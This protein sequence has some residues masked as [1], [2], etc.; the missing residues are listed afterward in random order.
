M[1]NIGDENDTTGQLRRE[2]AATYTR[3]RLLVAGAAAAV[4][5]AIWAK[6]SAGS[7]P[8]S[9]SSLPS[10]T[11]P[12]LSGPITVPNSTIEVDST[13][14]ENGF[15][16]ITENLKLGMVSDDVAQLQERLV[17]LKFDPGPV[18]GY[19]GE[20]TLRSAWAFQKL[21][22]QTPRAEAT[23]IITPTDWDVL[24]APVTIKPRRSTNGQ[25]N[26]TE[27]YLPE[28]VLAIFHKDQAVLVSHMASGKLDENGDPAEW[29][30]LVT[31]DT[32]ET[33]TPLEEPVERDICGRSKTP[34]GVFEFTRRVEGIR[35]GALGSMWNPVYFNFGIAIHGAIN[36]PAEPTSHGCVRLPMHIG[37]YFQDLVTDGDR[38]LVWNGEQPPEQVTEKEM[39]PVFDYAN[40]DATTTTTSTTST[41]T[42]TVPQTTTTAPPATTTPT[43][44]APTT[45]TTTVPATTSTTSVPASTTPLNG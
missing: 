20:S 30:E 16:P 33:G 13:A 6:V 31:I 1:T 9:E 36:V 22:L 32:D 2:S 5:L 29:C 15:G 41:T 10:T 8:A 12:S 28:Q 21:V 43:T 40:P 27:I 17:A 23:G 7:A 24:R 25:A 18:D 45:N 19:F 26:T 11:E 44:A 3:R 4:P 34:G 14:I 35:N 38:V 37:D 39:L 42:T